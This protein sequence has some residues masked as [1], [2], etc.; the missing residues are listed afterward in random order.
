MKG[1]S[2]FLKILAIIFLVEIVVMFLLT[3]FDVSGEPLRTVLDGILLAAFSSPFLYLFVIKPLSLQF[4]KQITELEKKSHSLQLSEQRLEEERNIFV[5]GPVVVF[6]WENVDGRPISY[7]SQNIESLL[8]YSAEEFTQGKAKYADII[9]SEDLLPVV[10]TH[11][12]AIASGIPYFEREY[13]VKKKD[14]TLLWVYDVTTI[15]RNEKQEIT[16]FHAYIADLTKRKEYENLF[17]SLFD[18]AREGIWVMDSDGKTLRMN[19]RMGDLLGVDP[20]SVTGNFIFDSFKNKEDRELFQDKE[21]NNSEGF[22]CEIILCKESGEEIPCLFNT[23]PLRDFAGKRIGSFAFVVDLTERKKIELALMGSEEKFRKMFASHSAMMLLINPLE[24]GIIV[25]ANSAASKFYGYPVETLKKM[26]ALDLNTLPEN[27][28]KIEMQ[29]AAEAKRN[30][31]FFKHRLAD[32]S[33]RDVEVHSSPVELQGNTLLFS[34]VHDVTERMKFE[35]ELREKREELEFLNKNL[36]GKVTEEI[37]KR[38][39]NEQILI[40]QSK[41]AAMGEMIGA[42]AHQWRQP[43]NALGLLIQDVQ[44]AYD[45]DELNDAYIADMVRKSMTQVNFMSKTIDDF[46]N[47]FRKDKEKQDFYIYK[48]IEDV[49]ALIASQ[50]ESHMILIK[51]ECDE[52]LKELT[53]NGYKNEFK[54]VILNLI[55][56]AKDALVEHVEAG[57][58]SKYEHGIINLHMEKLDGKLLVTV[59]DDAAGIPEDI[60]ERIFEPY[61]TTKEEGK[62]TGIGL[63]MSRTIIETN[64]GGK[65]CVEN[66]EGGGA[67][68]SVEVNL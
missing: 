13:R 10:E 19:E 1:L 8:G 11:N 57:F 53:I 22:H 5:A 55:A 48:S 15:I 2:I 30:I 6:K 52:E 32:G 45:F 42:I 46:R 18:N 17:H 60:L 29:R 35:N 51:F 28:L 33:I 44:D 65:L 25:D 61:Y 21:K 14:G 64:M 23:A 31:F 63:Y 41:L 20:L 59:Q 47:F 50:L 58:R 24:K 27:R 9:Y 67:K 3:T 7:V 26:K 66:V 43:L 39:S 12:T 56:N 34:I 36:E 40:Q 62:G 68:F 4:T 16:H 49:L 54:Q 38:R 37:E